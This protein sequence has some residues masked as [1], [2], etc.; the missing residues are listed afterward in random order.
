MF[1]MCPFWVSNR[2]GI[3]YTRYFEVECG[4]ADWK[5]SLSLVLLN[6][7]TYRIAKNMTYFITIILFHCGLSAFQYHIACKLL[8]QDCFA[9]ITNS[10][11][12]YIEQ[13]TVFS[14]RYIYRQ[15]TFYSLHICTFHTCIHQRSQNKTLISSNA[16]ANGCY[17]K[18]CFLNEVCIRYLNLMILNF[19]ISLLFSTLSYCKQ[20]FT[21]LVVN[22]GRDCRGPFLTNTYYIQ[23][24]R[25][26]K[27]NYL[28]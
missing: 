19:K 10:I 1:V 18:Y 26:N 11:Y 23:C 9:E 2:V 7:Y 15:C 28:F 3:D 20:G 22:E 5:D 25:Q 17:E 24:S 12:S 6:R 13:I 21:M 14:V 16:Y 4:G 8:P 27:N